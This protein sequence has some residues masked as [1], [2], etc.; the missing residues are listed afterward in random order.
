VYKPPFHLTPLILKLVAEIQQIVGELQAQSLVVKPSIKLRRENKIKTVHHSLAIEG[1]TLNEKQVT[2][3]LE[4]KKVMGPQSQILEVMNALELYDQISLLKPFK[5]KDFLRAHKTLMKGLIKT[6]GRYRITSVGILKSGKVSKIAP[7][8]KQVPQLMGQLFEFL[9]HDNDVHL[10]I[11]ACVFHYELEFIHPF[12]DGNGRMGRSWQQRILM[13]HSPVFEYLAVESWIHRQQKNYYRA[14]EKSDFD[15]HSTVF[16]E[17]SLDLI[18]KELKGFYAQYRPK[19]LGVED[20][21]GMAIEHFGS[22]SFSRKDYQ[23]LHR[24]ISAPTASRDLA[25]AVKV[26]K[27]FLEGT[28][29]LA[30][31]RARN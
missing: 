13:E 25:Q 4:N 24:N 7:S 23:N 20:R 12:T 2:A 11:K 18:L 21:I 29:A 5:E 26:K 6:S 17:F 31:Y 27:L 8:A 9:N 28:K 10:L 3:L 15:G 1:N 30:K 16:I 22:K 14:L 19:K